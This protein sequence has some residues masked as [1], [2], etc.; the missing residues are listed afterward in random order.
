MARLI[1]RNMAFLG[2]NGALLLALNIVSTASLVSVRHPG[3][4]HNFLEILDQGCSFLLGRIR[5][6]DQR[7]EN[8]ADATERRDLG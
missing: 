3:H 1:S 4:P 5:W 7:R 6:T 8:Q 2:D